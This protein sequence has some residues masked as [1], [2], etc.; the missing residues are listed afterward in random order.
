MSSTSSSRPVATL[1]GWVQPVISVPSLTYQC[2]LVQ[3]GWRYG[4]PP[5]DVWFVEE[6]GAGGSSGELGSWTNITGDN[7]VVP[8]LARAGN[9][10]V[11]LPSDDATCF[12][13]GWDMAGVSRSQG[14][15]SSMLFSFQQS[16]IDGITSATPS[17]VVVTATPSVPIP[18]V[19]AG[20]TNG[21]R[22]VGRIVGPV[23]GVLAVVVLVVG[24]LCMRRRKRVGVQTGSGVDLVEGEERPVEQPAPTVKGA[25]AA[26]E[27]R[28]PSVES[29]SG[30]E[31]ER[32]AAV[33]ARRLERERE[34]PPSYEARE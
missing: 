27:P 25:V 31:L 22:S 17:V 28:P 14:I 21:N 9:T 34:A 10:F 20:A 1:S 6:K 29:L 3:L 13:G 32:L 23:V 7:I 30:P 11:V 4:L 16:V 18:T 15:M 2:E 24:V 12:S 19:T 5:F 26:R 8:C 33:V